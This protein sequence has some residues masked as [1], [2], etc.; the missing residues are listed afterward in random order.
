MFDW[1]INISPVCLLV[2]VLSRSYVFV[3]ER[4]IGAISCFDRYHT[5]IEMI[6]NERGLGDVFIC[7]LLF[8]CPGNCFDR[9]KTL[10]D[11]D[12]RLIMSRACCWKT[13]EVILVFTAISLKNAN[14]I[15]SS[16]IYKRKEEHLGRDYARRH[17]ES[18]LSLST[19]MQHFSSCP[20]RVFF[21]EQT[22][23]S[24]PLNNKGLTL[25]NP[26]TRQETELASVA[27][28]PPSLWG[29]TYARSG[30]LLW[31]C[32]SR[33]SVSRVG[34]EGEMVRWS[35]DILKGYIFFCMSRM[36]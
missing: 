15:I 22:D 17:L 18:S 2:N 28:R 10:K 31:N 20:S 23:D 29:R 9:F 32:T 21:S 24:L 34:H 19:V 11:C 33:R 12:P 13:E 5:W 1:G 30:F 8:Q 26:S 36:I 35:F 14:Y 6:A 27:R 4:G 3:Y 7:N 16:A 25:L